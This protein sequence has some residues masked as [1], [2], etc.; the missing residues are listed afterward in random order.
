MSGGRFELG[1]GG[2]WNV[3]S[4]LFD[5]ARRASRT[6]GFRQTIYALMRVDNVSRG[7]SERRSAA[8][9]RQYQLYEW[10]P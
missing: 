4:R 10:T 7:M 9:F 6:R 3:G 1:A 8:R 2:G 5:E